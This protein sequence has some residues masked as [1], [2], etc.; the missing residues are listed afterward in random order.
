LRVTSVSTQVDTIPYSDYESKAKSPILNKEQGLYSIFSKSGSP[1]RNPCLTVGG[2]PASIVLGKS[3][4]QQI[5]SLNLIL[6]YNLIKTLMKNLIILTSSIIFSLS[7]FYVNFDISNPEKKILSKAESEKWF[8]CTN[9]CKTKKATQAP[10]QQGCSKSSSGT[11]N[12]VF[13][14][15]AGN[16]NY[17]CRNCDAEVYLTSSTSPSASRCCSSGNTHNWYN[18]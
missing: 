10:W 17:T 11:H 14:G 6:S 13:V 2:V 5:K 1:G 8:I 16:Y 9:C 15:V 12:Y 18:R 7:F 3:V 4:E